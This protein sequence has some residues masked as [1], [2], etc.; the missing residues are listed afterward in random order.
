M[1][2][3]NAP[4]RTIQMAKEDSGGLTSGPLAGN[5][6]RSSEARAVGV[7]GSLSGL[8]LGVSDECSASV[9]GNDEAPL[10]EDFHSPPDG[11]VAAPVVL[12]Q[13]TFRQKPR[14]WLQFTGGD[15]GGDVVSNLGIREVGVTAATRLK[16]TH[17]TT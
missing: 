17:S 13:G 12:G 4:V 15:P 7:P 10:T 6:G 9:N 16:I 11:L 14:A 2:A 5:G 1:Q 3:K 8:G